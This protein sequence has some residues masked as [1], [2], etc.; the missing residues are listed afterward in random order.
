MQ[1]AE[2][3]SEPVMDGQVLPPYNKS[4]H[5]SQLVTF[6]FDRKIRNKKETAKKV[7]RE[8]FFIISFVCKEG[9]LRVV[10]AGNEMH[11]TDRIYKTQSNKFT[12]GVTN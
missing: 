12:V 9:V 6:I 7:F 11:R 10:K 8:W 1:P 2:V 5:G 4:H 3:W